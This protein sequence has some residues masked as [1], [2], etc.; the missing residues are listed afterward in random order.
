ML[1]FQNAK[2]SSIYL[3]KCWGFEMIG[4]QNAKASSE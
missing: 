4:F 3:S 1:G 2:V